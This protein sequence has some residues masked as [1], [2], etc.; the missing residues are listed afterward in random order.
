MTIIKYV[1]VTDRTH[2]MSLLARLLLDSL[3]DILL[4]GERYADT[5]M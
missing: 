4:G 5:G 2:I 3:F 1:V